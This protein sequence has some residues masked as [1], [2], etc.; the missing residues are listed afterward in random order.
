MSDRETAEN[1]YYYLNEAIKRE[2]ERSLEAFTKAAWHLIEPGTPL[3]WNW[4]LS[5]I[6]G[7]LEAFHRGELPDKR[8]II[9]VPPGTL[10]SILVSVMYPA[11]TWIDGPTLR[12][13]CITNEQGLAI[14]DAL[15][16]KQIVS[17]DWFQSKWTLELKS[18]QNEKTLYLNDKNGHRQSQGITASNTGKRGDCMIIDDPIDAKHAFSDVIRQSVND[19]WDQ[20]LSSRLNHLEES[21]VLLIMQR[22]HELD[23][24]GYLRDKVKSHWTLLQIP[25]RYEGHQTYDS[26][27][28]IG[29]PELNDPRTT[30]GDLLFPSRF[31]E[32]AVQSLEEDLGEYGTAGQLQQRP[33][34]LGGGI[35]KQSWWRVWPDDIKPPLCEHIFFSFDTAFSTQ[36]HKDTSYSAYTKW[37]IFWHEANNRHDI[38][39]LGCWAG[40][41]DY[42]DLRK[43]AADVAKKD[44]PDSVLI[45]KKASGQSLIQD[46]RRIK[47]PGGKIR[48]RAYQPDR[49]KIARAYAVQAMLQSGQVY[50]PNKPWANELIKQVAK[51]PSGAPPSS[52][53]TDTVTQAL[54]YLRNGLWVSHPDDVEDDIAEANRTEEDIDDNEHEKI[55]FYG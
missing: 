22:L 25:M 41:V 14:R 5:T 27:K 50:M 46:M 11:W 1:L 36:D 47:I 34:P 19:T 55:R 52:D 28:D 12:Y 39:L 3:V 20:S 32:R 35:L 48:I 30:K 40:R 23:L 49:D 44:K 45:E 17:S 2:C 26:G 10:K 8:L 54:L 31:S 53:Y 29:K 21:G 6:C 18:D 51:F 42:P 24:S 37:G 15:R 38:M 9:N 43:K 7:Y 33:S 16:M 4:H 13:L